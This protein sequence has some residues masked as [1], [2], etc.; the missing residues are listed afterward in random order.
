VPGEFLRRITRTAT[1]YS[2]T[3]GSGAYHDDAGHSSDISVT[4]P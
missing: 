3:A 4:N 1:V 2:T